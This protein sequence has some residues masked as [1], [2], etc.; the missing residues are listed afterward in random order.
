MDTTKPEDLYR[1]TS[2][3]ATRRQLQAAVVA[4]Y[5]GRIEALARRALPVQHVEEATQAGCIGLLLALE[6]Y[7]RTVVGEDR[8]GAFWNFARAHVLNEVQ[9]WA[10]VGVYWRPRKRNN[11]GDVEAARAQRRVA[12]LDVPAHGTEDGSIVE[13]IEA[14][15]PTPEDMAGEIEA[16]SHLRGFT[17]SLSAEDQEILFSENSKRVRSRRYLTLVEKA[18]AFVAGETASGYR[19]SVRRNSDSVRP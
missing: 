18:T 15:Q 4:E 6:K 12:S 1:S 17:V 8:G 19:N 7:D 11:R 9:Q 14:E 16:I 2:D 3:K 10:D 5:R 13:T